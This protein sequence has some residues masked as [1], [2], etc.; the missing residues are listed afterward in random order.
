M[1]SLAK[2]SE[3]YLKG[4]NEGKLEPSIL[5]RECCCCK[6]KLEAYDYV[7]AVHCCL[8]YGKRHQYDAHYNWQTGEMENCHC[9]TYPRPSPPLP[10]PHGCFFDINGRKY[11]VILLTF[12]EISFFPQF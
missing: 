4:R 1:Q 6:E 11:K 3:Q 7:K 2:F 10:F 5:V 9:G 12:L 8:R